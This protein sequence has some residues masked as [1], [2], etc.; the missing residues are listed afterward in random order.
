HLAGCTDCRAIVEH[1]LIDSRPRRTEPPRPA[2]QA[3]TPSTQSWVTHSHL[4]ALADVPQALRDH[5]RYRILRPLGRGGMGVVYQAEHRVMERLVAVKVISRA[6]VDHP[7]MLERFHREVRAA[8]K[9]NHPNIVKAYD[10][11]QAGDLQ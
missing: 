2:S 3:D 4:P 5:S 1:T 6:L 11:E 8:A 9:L 7:E 10:A